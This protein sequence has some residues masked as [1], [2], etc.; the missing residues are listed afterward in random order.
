MSL[1]ENIINQ[2]SS[3]GSNGISKP[4]NFDMNDET[5]SKLL[6]KQLNNSSQI[7]LTNLIGEMGM[8]AGFVIEPYDATEFANTVQ[9]QLESI[10]ESKL[11]QKPEINL[12][13]FE[14]KDID[15]DNYFSNLLKASNDNSSDLMNFAKR[16]AT[17]AYNVFG[18]G[19]V[20][21]MTDFVE[22]VAS[23]L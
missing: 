19:F 8:P 12:E 22:D 2:I 20:T 15:M 6:E 23:S 1:V 16:Q 4:Q 13:D 7:N 3:Q 14:M 10:G 21:D 9:D 11:T 17:S 5:F 18:K